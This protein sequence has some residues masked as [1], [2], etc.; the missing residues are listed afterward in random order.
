[1]ARLGRKAS[2]FGE[3]ISLQFIT[4][5][6]LGQV[7]VNVQGQTYAN[8]RAIFRDVLENS[9]YHTEIRPLLNQSNV[10]SVNVGFNILSITE[11]NDVTQSFICNAFLGLNW[12]DELLVWNPAVYGGQD[13]IH[14]LPE[15]IWRPRM[16]LMNTL[17]DRDIFSD[18]KS[19]INVRNNG[20]VSWIPGSIIP[21]S[22]E[23]SL[24]NYP[25]DSQTCVIQMV[26]MSLSISELKYTASETGVLRTFYTTNGEWDLVKAYINISISATGPIGLSAVD[27]T[28]ELK[29]RPTF[30]LLNLI[31]PV[32]FLSFL[33]ILV[34]IIPVESGEKIGYGIT[35]LLA[36]T[37]F[38]SIISS[39][40][41]RSSQTVP[42]VTVYLFILLIISL[43]TVAD[44]IIIVYVYHMDEKEEKHIKAQENFRSAFTKMRHIQR[45]VS[46]IA[47]EDNSEKRD[48]MSFSESVADLKDHNSDLPRKL[49]TQISEGIPQM[50]EKFEK[51]TNNYRIVGK[52]ID[53]ISFIVFMVLWFA[54]TFGFLLSMAL[55]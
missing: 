30:L 7:E 53:K 52:H 38:M 3:C 17:E 24:V 33:N 35:V 25:F 45:A 48:V 11:V 32:V 8:T 55:Y 26:S 41:P 44:T 2:F 10:M 20:F 4:L 12:R 23:L 50:G 15:Q 22:C 31:L 28:F 14:P 21:I 16:I 43:L 18:N 6:I 54:V 49:R 42:K 5:V 37:V 47:K 9:D 13:L 34:F 19:P 29:R 39:M 46:P 51:V 40:L 27:I 1:M 36:L